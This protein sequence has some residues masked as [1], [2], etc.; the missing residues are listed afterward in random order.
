MRIAFGFDIFYPETNGVITTTINLANNLVD[1]GHEVYFFV[2]EDKQFTAD[3]IENNIEELKYLNDTIYDLRKSLK[4][5]PIYISK[6]STELNRSY[7]LKPDTVLKTIYIYKDSY[8]DIKLYN[9]SIPKVNLKILTDI[10]YNIIEYS[11][12]RED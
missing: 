10:N 3:V 9:D 1:L 4:D 11:K 12:S 6:T 7:H 2:P 8:T 5:K